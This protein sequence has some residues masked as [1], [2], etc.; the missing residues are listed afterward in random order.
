MKPVVRVIFLSAVIMI[1]LLSCAKREKPVLRVGTGA[2]YPP[3][4]YLN[5]NQLT[6]IEIDIAKKIAE[7]M[8][9]GIEFY[10]MSFDSLFSSLASNKIDMAISSITITSE[11]K[12]RF[13]FSLPYAVTNQV[14]IAKEDSSIKI[15]K[16][17]DLGKYTI[18]SLAATTGYEYLVENLVDRDLM[19]KTNLK[20]YP[21]TLE[22]LSEL[23]K[24]N[25]DFVSID[26]SAAEGYVKLKPIKIVYTIQTNEQ[27]GILM[28][29]GKGINDTINKSLKE[30]ID[31]GEVKSIIQSYTK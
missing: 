30:L 4:A 11:R 2:E 26:N 19:P 6:G 17:E 15:D 13:D 18:G 8:K 1:A 20:Q 10:P 27:Y 12:Q 24:G 3:Y 21:T 9:V 7:K 28:Q 5:D 25:L 31:S 29:K 14:L 23:L 16:F 22:S